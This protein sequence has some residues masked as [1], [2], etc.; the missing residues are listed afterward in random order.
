MTA[1]PNPSHELSPGTKPRV[2]QAIREPW[3]AFCQDLVARR[4]DLAQRL[5]RAE[6]LVLPLLLCGGSE[7]EIATRL[8]RSIH[9]VRDHSKVIYRKLDVSNR[10]HLVLLFFMP[11]EITHCAA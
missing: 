11:A 4:G 6:L 1:E 3:L 10:V 7:L 8:H 5:S 9:T 2:K